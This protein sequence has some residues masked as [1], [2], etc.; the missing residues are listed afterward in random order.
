MAINTLIRITTLPIVTLRTLLRIGYYFR[1]KSIENIDISMKNR[2]S[3][4][5]PFSTPI[6]I[7][8]VCLHLSIKPVINFPL[9]CA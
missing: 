8:I 9:R 5:I 2:T 6:A 1:V 3:N 4:L 7:L